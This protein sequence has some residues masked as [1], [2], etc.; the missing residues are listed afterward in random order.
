MKKYQNTFESRNLSFG[1]GDYIFPKR[2]I[3]LEMQKIFSN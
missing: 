3:I 1:E 2:Y